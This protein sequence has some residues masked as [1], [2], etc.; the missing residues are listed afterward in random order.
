MKKR[1]GFKVV[2]PP[3]YEEREAKGQ[4]PVCAKPHE[5]GIR[6]GS[7]GEYVQPCSKDCRIEFWDN[8]IYGAAGLRKATFKRDNYT[9]VKCG[10]GV[11]HKSDPAK[12]YLD[13]DADH[14][15]PIAL[16]G[17]QWD[18]DNLQTLCRECHKKKTRE[19]IRRIAR[20]RHDEKLEAAFK[21]VKQKR[22]RDFSGHKT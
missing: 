21:R 2:K 8:V 19:D 9:C 7:N 1:E 13:G 3:E 5:K 18:L 11:E 17:D 6:T 14:I 15:E 12:P 22:L 20:K 10:R 4:C 16:G